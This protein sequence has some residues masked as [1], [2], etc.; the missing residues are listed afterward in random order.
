MAKSTKKSAHVISQTKYWG[1]A[2]MTSR[3][4]EVLYQSFYETLTIN[5]LLGKELFS[6]ATWLCYFNELSPGR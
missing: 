6:R 3:R 5:R 1:L 4:M 2:V